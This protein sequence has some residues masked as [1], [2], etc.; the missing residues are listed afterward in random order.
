VKESEAVTEQTTPITESKRAQHEG[1]EAGRRRQSREHD[2]KRDPTHGLAHALARVSLG[3]LLRVL[4][5]LGDDVHRVR[6]PERRQ[7]HRH[8]DRDRVELVAADDDQGERPD[9]RDHDREQRQGDSAQAAERE[10]QHASERRQDQQRQRRK[11]LLEVDACRH[12]ADVRSARDPDLGPLAL[13]AGDALDRRVETR[14]SVLAV[15]HLAEV[16]DQGRGLAVAR[17]QAASVDRILQNPPPQL[18]DRLGALGNL[19]EEGLDHDVVVDAADVAR[20]RD[21]EHVV[22]ALELLEARRQP[23]DAIQT[24]SAKQVVGVDREQQRLVLAEQLQDPLVE[25]NRLVPL[26]KQ[27]VHRRVGLQPDVAGQRIHDLS[28]RECGE[29]QR[30]EQDRPGVARNPR[31]EAFQPGHHARVLPLLAL[32]RCSSSPARPRPSASRVAACR[33][34]SARDRSS[35]VRSRSVRSDR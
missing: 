20:V 19:R 12:G 23:L 3:G 6:E 8:Q 34:A 16:D 5:V 2:R 11:G 27:S 4:V 13:L 32:K 30:S 22:H 31:N 24:R 14:G 17:D 28:Q 1:R 29:Q 33:A 15:R 18:G 9:H 10:Q 35:S 25:L 7:Q 21:R 26:G